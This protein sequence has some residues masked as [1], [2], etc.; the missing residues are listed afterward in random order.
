MPAIKID[1]TAPASVAGT[2]S[3]SPNANGWYN[4]AVGVAFHGT[5]AMSGIASCTS[6]SY[7]GPDSANRNIA[8]SCRD[9]AGNLRTASFVLDYDATAPTEVSG[10]GTRV[11]DFGG[12]YNHTVSISFDG[13]DATSGIASCDTPSYSGPDSGAASVTG[14]CRD[15]AGNTSGLASFGFKYDET[16][17]TVTA[18]ASRP[19]SPQGWYSSPLEISFSATDATSLVGSCNPPA[20]YS[21]PDASAASVTGTCRDNAGNLGSRS[22]TIKYDATAPQATSASPTRPPDA[23]GWYNSPVAFTFAGTDGTSGI[24]VCPPRTYAGPDGAQAT[25]TG[26]CRDRAGNVSAPLAVQLKYDNTAPTVTGTTASRAPDSNGWYNRPIGFAFAG[27]DATS[28]FAG[29]VGKTYAGPDGG[30]ATVQGACRDVAGNT[31]ARS[32]PLRY[33]ASAPSVRVFPSRP[34]D[35]YGWYSHDVSL[36]FAGTDRVSGIAACSPSV[37]YGS[38]NSERASV[39]GGCTDRA[40]NSGGAVFGFKYSEPLLKPRSGARVSKP[41]LLDWVRVAGARRY[42]IQVWHN[43]KVLSRWPT[44]SKYKVRSSW[45]FNGKRYRLERGRY[46]WYVWPLLSNGRYGNRIG[47][48][49]FVVR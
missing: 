13:N 43:G 9:N 49:V 39:R 47:R 33:D 26:T 27:T 4:A 5:D 2:P 22:L 34:P 11:P 28:G 18:S 12:W 6:S 30:A 41:P 21:G 44:L 23:S 20:T 35:R 38:P 24:D 46:T 8:G 1:K 15:R 10:A 37:S 29:C 45:R 32:F 48:S 42:N 40:G 7:N 17:P 3:R 19:P 36:R 14:T 25:H 31:G 16:P